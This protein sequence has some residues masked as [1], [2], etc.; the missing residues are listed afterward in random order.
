[1]INWILIV[2]ILIGIYIFIKSTGF[3]YSNT[4][5]W[6]IGCAV[7]FFVLTFGF[8]I[9]RPGVD[10]GTVEGLTNALK[11]YFV[12]LGSIIKN[13]AGITGQAFNV[14]WTGNVTGVAK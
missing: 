7:V 5:A 4:W 1:M 10:V 11:I 6:I 12:W 2:I 9:T 8:V 3:Q 14:D 13:T